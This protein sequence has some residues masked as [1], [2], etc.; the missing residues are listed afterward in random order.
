MAEGG[1]TDATE[2]PCGRLARHGPVSYLEIPAIDIEQS[3]AF[4]EAVFSWIIHRR[5]TGNVSFDDRSGDLIGRWDTANAA[6]TSP[7]FVPHI[8]VHRIDE[9]LSR[10][11][12]LGGELVYA[13]YPEG[14]LWVVTFRDPAGNVLG[15]WQMGPR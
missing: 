8:Y 10:V 5:D 7:G 4:Y 12:E 11:V 14:D 3:S 9:V 2:A 15:I 6:S 13:A 1:V